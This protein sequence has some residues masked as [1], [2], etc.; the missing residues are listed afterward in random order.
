MQ[1]LA[2]A[3]LVTAFV[4]LVEWLHWRRV[5]RVARLAFGTSGHP[6]FWV[7]AVPILRPLA[8]GAA[9]WGLLFLAT[10]DP[11]EI[12]RRPAR[13]ASKHILIALD[14]SP[15]MQIKDAGP[16]VAKMSR[17]AWAGRVVQGILDRIDME[18]T[19]ITVVAFYTDVLPIV[20]ETYDKE[21]IRN[22]L[23]GLP[24]WI[25]FEPGP[26]DVQKGVAKALEF[27][28][29]WPRGSATLVVVTDG[30]ANAPSVPAYVPASVADTIVIG[31]GDSSRASPVGGH[32]S[33]QNPTS[34][35]QLALRLNGIYHN[36]NVKHVPSDV[37]DRLTMIQ[38]RIGDKLAARD[39]ALLAAGF[40]C[41]T[42]ALLGPA[43]TLF[44]RPRAFV[45][46]RRPTS[47]SV[48]RAAL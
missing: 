26:T 30:D 28:R 15:S 34:L 4:V 23:D 40:G 8:A 31:V 9:A 2:I 35:Q 5:A 45:R 46:G 6:T 39:A 14:V 11:V 44:G 21:V 47:A 10:F 25:A 36:G 19:R 32:S 48:A 41:F 22:A 37:L 20:Q 33:R 7:R 13:D 12:D 29:P 3:V 18:T 42:L 1:Y 17:A 38:P 43:L 24:M 16:D 27:A